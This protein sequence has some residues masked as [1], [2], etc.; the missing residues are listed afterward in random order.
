MEKMSRQIGI[1][2]Q[3]GFVGKRLIEFLTLEKI[4]YIPYEGDLLN[5]KNSVKFFS[6]ND[7]Q[8][9]IHL[10]GTFNPPFKN[11]IKKNVN[12]T[13]SLLE[14]GRK[15]GLKKIIYASTAA[16]YG[17]PKKII[18]TETDEPTP[19][20]LYGISKLTAE[21]VIQYYRITYGIEFVILRF[22]TIYGDGNDK[23]VIYNISHDIVNNK[24]A[25]IHGD[26]NQKR[27]FLHVDDACRAIIKSLYYRQS[28]IFNIASTKSIS[29][30]EVVNLY[31]KKYDFKVQ[32]E[33]G[34]NNLKIMNID[35][36]K[37]FEELK[38]KPLIKQIIL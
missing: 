35:T 12:T 5:S 25:T 20:T 24:Q 21:K 30:N 33:V 4:P 37:A 16:V 14:E 22:S 23:G 13:Y 31:K 29:I 11:L 32:Y 10:A 36:R 28:D 2:G 6:K 26:G 18:S 19:D 3:K 17:K 7:V 34:D 27:N 9:I 1:T 8:T 38:F 15:H